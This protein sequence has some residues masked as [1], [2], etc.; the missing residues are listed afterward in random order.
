MMDHHPAVSC[1][2]PCV[3]SQWKG[4]DKKDSY[5][6]VLI[7]GCTGLAQRMLLVDR[8]PK[9][10]KVNRGRISRAQAAT[11]EQVELLSLALNLCFG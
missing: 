11:Q 10:R 6:S 4:V 3:K 1:T 7:L 8:I 9:E 2:A 5:Q